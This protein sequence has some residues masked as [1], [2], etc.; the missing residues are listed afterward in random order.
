MPS[1]II[2]YTRNIRHRICDATFRGVWKFM[3]DICKTRRSQETWSVPRYR[4]NRQFEYPV[5]FRS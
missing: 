2:W 1:M 3:S 4:E 5:C